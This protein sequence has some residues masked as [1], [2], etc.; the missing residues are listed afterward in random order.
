M[1]T[2]IDKRSTAK[3]VLLMVKANEVSK[4]EGKKFLGARIEKKLGQ[5]IATGE[6]WMLA[7]KYTY[8]AF[9]ELSGLTDDLLTQHK[10]EVMPEYDPEYFKKQ[11]AAKKETTTE[12]KPEKTPEELEAYYATRSVKQ[13]QNWLTKANPD[14]IKYPLIKAAIAAKEAGQPATKAPAKKVTAKD[15]KEIKTDTPEPDFMKALEEMKAL[16]ADTT[17]SPEERAAYL[18]MVNGIMGKK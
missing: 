9:N 15:F 5:A 4:E 6:V 17:K 18:V 1:T 2:S 14:G 16:A 10:Q 8:D 12:D 13:L 3:D 7:T 11:R